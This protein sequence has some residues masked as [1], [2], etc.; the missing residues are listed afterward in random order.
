MYFMVDLRG[1]LLRRAHRGGGREKVF[2]SSQPRFHI[3]PHLPLVVSVVTVDCLLHQMEAAP[4]AGCSALT[5]G[6]RAGLC[7]SAPHFSLPVS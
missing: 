3:A 5:L 7:G 1:V 6:S 4:E 2:K